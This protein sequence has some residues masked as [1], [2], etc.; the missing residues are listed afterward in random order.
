M[1]DPLST[2]EANPVLFKI[3]KYNEFFNPLDAIL[4]NEITEYN[5]Y[6]NDLAVNIDQ[7]EK[8]FKGE[9]I[10]LD[11]YLEALYDLSNN[12]IPKKWC[13]HYIPNKNLSIE[14]WKVKIKKAFDDLNKW[15]EDSYLY[16]YDI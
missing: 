6:I 16:E 12:F 5:K 3:N 4:Q 8:I 14:D 2:Q 7:I 11:R 9:M 15:I 1:P 10:C 13:V